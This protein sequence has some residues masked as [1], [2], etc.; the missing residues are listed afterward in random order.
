MDP[1]A[2]EW[3]GEHVSP[4]S[5]PEPVHLRPWADVWRV[6]TRRGLVWFKACRAVQRFEP[7][8]TAS[9]AER[10]PG[11]VAD[12]LAHDDAQGFLLLADA[13]RQL[14]ELGNPPEL[15][16]RVLPAYAELQRGEA[17]HVDDHLRHGVP[18]L[19]S[20][21]VRRRFE[22]L[23]DRDLPI[24]AGE[25]LRL[26][27]AAADL[28]R[29]CQQ[30]VAAGIP[31]TVQH[32]DLHMT[33]VFTGPSGLRVLDWGDSSIGQPFGSLVVT[34]RFLEKRNGL[35]PRNPWF[36]RLR[37]AYLEPWGPVGR[38]TF[39]VAMKVG[40]VAHAVAS[41][42]QR[43]GLAAAD[44]ADFDDDFAAVLRLALRRIN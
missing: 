41:L 14:A 38:E 44:R 28:E 32:D 36:A 3:I 34:F 6:P 10:W 1:A 29:W 30:L 8:L 40:S 9:L 25:R 39:D 4:V 22:E 33:N 21:T 23:L 20:S 5:A 11:R 31:D 15:W 2:E 7:R 12:V 13:G 19:R 35:D 43:D 26:A 18:D 24:A 17:V 16:L 37:D 42:R 27:E